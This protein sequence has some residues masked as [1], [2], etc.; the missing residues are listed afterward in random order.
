MTGTTITI[1]DERLDRAANLMGLLADAVATSGTEEDLVR[2][3][4]AIKGA[5]DMLYALGFDYRY[6]DNSKVV[7]F[8]VEG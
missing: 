2:A 1:T 3:Q 8:E 7:V 4:A 5:W 6:D